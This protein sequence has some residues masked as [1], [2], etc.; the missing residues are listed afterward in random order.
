MKLCEIKKFLHNKE[1][2]FKL[3]QPST[4][5]D[6]SDKGLTTRIYRELKKLNSKNK[7]KNLNDPIKKWATELNLTFSEEE[8]PNG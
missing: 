1:M 2:V 8:S 5:W 7:K 3:K 4:K 6:V